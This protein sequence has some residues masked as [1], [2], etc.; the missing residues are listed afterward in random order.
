MITTMFGLAPGAWANADGSLPG[1]RPGATST[2]E[3]EQYSG[4]RVMVLA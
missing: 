1:S 2:G 4:T 3:G